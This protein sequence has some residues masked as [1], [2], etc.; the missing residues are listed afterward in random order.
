MNKKWL[1]LFVLVLHTI[2]NSVVAAVHT[3][4]DD[5]TLYEPS[6]IHY[7]SEVSDQPIVDMDSEQNSPL[8]PTHLHALFDPGAQPLSI[9]AEY[10]VIPT[11]KVGSI[12]RAYLGL[13]YKPA[14]PPPNT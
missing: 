5:H 9:E 2:F 14:V 3:S 8:E 4:S 11:V 12:T 13:T 1:L 6:H 7:S 10:T